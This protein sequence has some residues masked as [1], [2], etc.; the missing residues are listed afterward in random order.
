MRAEMRP[1]WIACVVLLNFL[2]HGPA[3]GFER[4]CHI[5]GPRYELATDTV[6]WTMKIASG[7]SCTRG[8]RFYNVAIEH[9]K[10]VSLPQSG[11][12]TL[13][14]PGFTYTARSNFQGQDSFVILVSGIANGIHGSSTIRIT[15][16]A[17]GAPQTVRLQAH[18]NPA[19][20][21]A[22]AKSVPTAAQDVSV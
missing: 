10:L 21:E 4:S 5:T 18:D 22:T 8:L 2:L 3:A 1:W 16:L 13:Q 7:Q 12:V 15:V 20:R 11:W 14:G 17:G 6:E 9:V 19:T